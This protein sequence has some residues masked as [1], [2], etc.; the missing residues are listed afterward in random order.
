MLTWSEAY[1]HGIGV[2]LIAVVAIIIFVL[3]LIVGIIS[4]F[5]P[6]LL[7]IAGIGLITAIIIG[8]LAILPVAIAWQFNRAGNDSTKPK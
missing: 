5:L 2:A 6:R 4:I 7:V 3:S 1:A 8:L